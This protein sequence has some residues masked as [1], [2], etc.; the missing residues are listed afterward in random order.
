MQAPLDAPPPQQPPS[1]VPFKS[2][3]KSQKQARNG[4]ND[5]GSDPASL[6]TPTSRSYQ[7]TTPYQ[8]NKYQLP[9]QYQAKNNQVFYDKR[10]DS[11][12]VEARD[13]TTDV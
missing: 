12:H 8:Q 6:P 13:N 9:P 7:G 11:T 2:L 10:S 4:S 5:T 3:I 1:N